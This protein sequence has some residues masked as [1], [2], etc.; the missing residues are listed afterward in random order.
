[1]KIFKNKEN[2]QIFLSS[3][4]LV[5]I[6]ALYIELNVLISKANIK[7]IDITEDM[8]YS[9]SKDSIEKI[10][11]LDKDVK[12]Y[13]IN[14]DKYEDNTYVN[15]TLYILQKYEK[16]SNRITIDLYNNNNEENQQNQYPYMIFES[17]GRT[18]TISINELYQY[19]YN[20]TYENQE[21]LSIIEPMITNSIVGVANGFDNRVYICL[22]KSVYSERM[23]T[24]ITNVVGTLGMET[25]ALNLEDDETIPDECTCIIIPPLVNVDELGNVNIADFSDKEKNKL[26][27]YIGRGGNILFLQES[28][29]LMNGE[30]P[31]LDYIMSLYGFRITDGIIC[32]DE[33]RFQNKPS[34]IYPTIK[35]NDIY[36]SLNSNSKVC[37]FDAGRIE[38][39][40]ESDL[41]VSHRILLE[42]SSNAYLRTDMNDSSTSRSEN[43]IDAKNAIIGVYAE[44]CIGDNK[45][46]AI[47]Y[48]NSVVATN[49]TVYINDSVRNKKVA[50][51]A[52]LLDDNIDMVADSLKTLSNNSESIYI[53]KS[54]YNLVPSKAILTDKITLKIIFIIPMIVVVLGYIVWKHRKNKK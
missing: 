47:L 25:Y 8:A 17:E 34:H 31:N 36:K 19:K 15:D 7:K 41:N 22:N 3:L 24:S 10:S 54:K 26:E 42:A 28:K 30:T 1:M 9:I 46:K 44:K 38:L 11:N 52:I 39:N 13:L 49:S 6:L 2:K 50:I 12:I 5:I 48:S 37:F 33:N 20:T 32:Q 40:D 23:Y 14:F 16:L 43:D 53:S 35:E 45:S 27:E 29:S 18:R 51:E 4:L 21:E